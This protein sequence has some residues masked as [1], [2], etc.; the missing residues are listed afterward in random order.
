RGY[1][2]HGL[3]PEVRGKVRSLA[4]IGDLNRTKLMQV[5]RAV[6]KEI[7]GKSG[8]GSGYN[9]GSKHNTGLSRNGPQGSR[10]DWVMVKNREGSNGGGAKSGSGGLRSEKLGH[11]DR[12]RTGPRDRG[13]T[14]LSYNELMERKQK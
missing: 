8:S 10:S 2:L 14:H 4:S 11:G 6:E 1:F 13:F 12:K 5:T 9:R 3:K 7:N